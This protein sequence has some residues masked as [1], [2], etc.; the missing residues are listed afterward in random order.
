MN[1][2]AAE[3]TGRGRARLA[4]RGFT[5]I[6]LLVVIAIIAILAALLLPALASARE[7]SR[8]SSCTNNLG[9]IGKNPIHPDVRFIDGAFA[10]KA[11]IA[12]GNV[13]TLANLAADFSQMLAHQV[14]ILSLQNGRFVDLNTQTI[15]RESGSQGEKTAKV[16]GGTAVAGAITRPIP[17]AMSAS[18]GKTSVR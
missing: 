15:N 3:M 10:Q 16:A 13:D 9:Q 2:E 18:R 17:T 11:Q 1:L 7:K 4:A 12:L 5:L 14:Q 8:R 6:E